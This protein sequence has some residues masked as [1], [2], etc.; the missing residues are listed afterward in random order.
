MNIFCTIKIVNLIKNNFSN[1]KI[2][3][4]IIKWFQTKKLTF[5][6]RKYTQKDLFNKKVIYFIFVCI[7][8]KQINLFNKNYSCFYSFLFI[9]F[10]FITFFY[11]YDIFG[12]KNNI[13]IFSKKNCQRFSDIW[14]FYFILYTYLKNFNLDVF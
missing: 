14:N 3:K 9:I 13:F 4:I 1:K 6:S 12:I 7:F 8:F 2:Q 5:F 11:I 10:L